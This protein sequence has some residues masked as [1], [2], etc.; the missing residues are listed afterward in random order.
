MFKIS[1]RSIISPFL[2]GKGI[3]NDRLFFIIVNQ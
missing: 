1:E 3:L 2:I